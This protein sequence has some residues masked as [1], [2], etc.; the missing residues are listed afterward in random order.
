MNFHWRGGGAVNQ[1]ASGMKVPQYGPVAAA[2]GWELK[3]FALFSL[4]VLTAET[5]K[6]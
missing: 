4:Q 1:G 3:Q 2:P 6:I 5:I